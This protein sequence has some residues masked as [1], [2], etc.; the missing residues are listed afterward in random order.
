M[1]YSTLKAVIFASYWESPLVQF[2]KFK[3]FL[4]V[5]RFLCKNL[6]N[7]VP[8]P[9]KLHNPYCHRPKLSSIQG[10]R[11]NL[12]YIV[13]LKLSKTRRAKLLLGCSF[14]ESFFWIWIFYLRQ[15]KKDSK[16]QQ[17]FNSKKNSLCGNLYDFNIST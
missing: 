1:K 17:M 9:W 2:S 5:C 11:A 15:K 3:K 7:F 10:I 16:R 4:W 12:V 6:S 14:F 8:L 13:S